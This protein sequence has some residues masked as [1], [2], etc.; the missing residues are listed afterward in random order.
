MSVTESAQVEFNKAK[1]HDSY[2]EIGEISFVGQ[3]PP[4]ATPPHPNA[5][6]CIAPLGAIEVHFFLVLSIT[7]PL[8]CNLSHAT[9]F[10][11]QM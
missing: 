5:R 11:T 2:V 10:V 7:S 1:G 8:K 4:G 9:P 3:E 6:T